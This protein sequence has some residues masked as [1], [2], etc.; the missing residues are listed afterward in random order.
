MHWD[1]ESVA[2]P[3]G[4][5]EVFLNLFIR[6]QPFWFTASVQNVIENANQLICTGWKQKIKKKSR[7]YVYKYLF[8]QFSGFKEFFY[9]PGPSL[10]SGQIFARCAIL[11]SRWQTWQPGRHCWAPSSRTRHPDWYP[12]SLITSPSTASWT[13]QVLISRLVLSHSRYSHYPYL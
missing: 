12:S 5:F 9:V 11:V 8:C 1:P 13:K 7:H 4:K 6:D 10:M 2:F 3:E